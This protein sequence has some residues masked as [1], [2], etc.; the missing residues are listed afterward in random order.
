MAGGL[1]GGAGGGGIAE[2]CGNQIDENGNGVFD[3]GCPCAA[4]RPCYRD[5]LTSPTLRYPWDGGSGCAAGT[6]ACVGSVYGAVC[7]NEHVPQLEFC[8]GQDTDCDGLPDPPTCPCQPGRPCFQG[9]PFL[10]GVGACRQGTWNCSMPAG[11]QCV[12]QV[13]PAIAE[14]CNGLDDDCNGMTDEAAQTSPC[15]PGVCMSRDRV[16][17]GGL[18]QVCLYSSNPPPNYSASEICGDGLDNECDG[19]AD[20]GCTCTVGAMISCWTGSTSACPTDGGACLGV[21][22]RGTQS[23]ANLSDGGTGY[24]TCGGQTPA[25]IESCSDTLDNDCDGRADCV[26]TDCTGRACGANGRA[27]L[28]NACSCIDRDG[29]VGPAAETICNDAYDNDCDGLVDC[30]ETACAS[31]ACG[32][33]GRRCVGTTCTCVVDGGVFQ[34]SEATCNDGLDN[35]C[36]GQ[37]DCAEAA[38]AGASCGANG[39]RCNG[40]ACQC[41]LPDGGVGQ[42]SEATCNDG[43]DN[44]C[45]GTTDCMDS[46]CSTATNCM[47]GVE[48][49]TDGADND[50]DT[51]ADC[52]D[53]QCFHKVCSA[54][55]SSNVCCGTTCT[56]L[57]T[58]TSC[59]QCGLACL[60]GSTCM[61]IGTGAHRSGFCSCP[62][63]MNSQCPRPAGFA[64]QTCVSNQCTCSG[65]DDRCGD[66]AS[67]QAS[68]C[69]GAS[70]DY[71]H[72]Q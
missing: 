39:R 54:T 34:M 60:S 33:F 27:C 25:S 58:Q 1:A 61:P 42:A 19:Q 4:P 47:T 10:A 43:L 30:A 36:D 66:A 62:T 51:L 26:D 64:A 32:T 70:V 11:Q 35:D 28:N 16:C 50:G 59:G 20:D 8:D 21:C 53:P 29:G 12:G 52:A 3:D 6:Q 68:R 7:E 41:Q 55:D 9:T 72:Y 46:N 31:Q 65:N 57:V 56:S 17:A 2:V 44:D 69:I 13:L 38:C 23:C 37:I 14:T 24:G 5:G 18:E 63:G 15:G 48:N 71:C 67:G 40:G 22:R 45:D 49:C